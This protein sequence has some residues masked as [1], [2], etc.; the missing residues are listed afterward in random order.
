MTM[1][2]ENFKKL[3][4]LGHSSAWDGSW[5]QA[6]QYYRQA[7]MEDPENTTALTSLGLALFESK[8]FD[9]ANKYY[10]RVARLKPEDPAPLEKIG[11]IYELQGKT[12]QAVQVYSYAADLLLRAQ[13]TARAL[14]TWQHVVTINPDHLTAHSRL[15]FIFEKIGQKPEAA[16]EYILTASLLQRSGDL[17]RSKQLLDRACILAPDSQQ[18]QEALNC[19]EHKQPIP[20]LPALPPVALVGTKGK[21]IE[22]SALKEPVVPDEQA[23]DPITE[24]RKR[25]VRKL[26]DILFLDSE[27]AGDEPEPGANPLRNITSSTVVGLKNQKDLA[28]MQLH[29]GKSIELQAQNSISQA[30]IELEQA[31]SAGLSEIPDVCYILG[32]LQ[33]KTDKTKALRNLEKSVLSP[34]YILASNLLIGQIH[35]M[36]QNYS[37]AAAAYLQALC[38]ADIAT[39]PAEFSGEVE[40]LYE[41]IIETQLQ[42]TDKNALQTLCENIRFQLIRSD[43]FAMIHA[44]RAQFVS[45][46]EEFIPLYHILLEGSNPREL[47]NLSI[48]RRLANVKNYSSAMNMA[49]DALADNPV[50]LPLHIQIGDMLLQQGR[51]QDALT[52][53]MLV[54]EI[55]TLR[56]EAPRAVRLLKRIIK[57]APMDLKVRMRLVDLLGTQNNDEE[58]VEQLTGLASIYYQQADLEKARQT[59]TSAL[60]LSQKTAKEH[61]WKRNILLN[62]ADIDTQRLDLRQAAKIYEQLHALEPDDLDIHSKLINTYFRIGQDFVAMQELEKYLTGCDNSG[63]REDAVNFLAGLVEQHPNNNGLRM[64]LAGLYIR[65]QQKEKAVSELDTLADHFLTAGKKEDAA[66]ILKKI[67]SLKPENAEEYSQALAELQGNS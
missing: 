2:Q 29:L 9:E 24:A 43:W 49:F 41:P 40:T 62:I 63:R 22:I 45:T 56:G 54:A 36:N 59:Y 10:I 61:S 37:Q 57:A 11:Q 39:S 50:Y 52:K 26:A 12:D 17:S 23:M 21:M 13:D 34:D 44:F 27:S 51:I 14:Q 8:E 7:L 60:R 4:D 48:I 30:V 47:E 25:A 6:A 64:R 32:L 66:A 67:I 33:Y 35:E 5:S 15:A 53:F 16:H 28:R 58:V 31:V 55:Y 65:S 18:A 46:D 42:S 19:V 3:M 1:T 20:P 38:Q